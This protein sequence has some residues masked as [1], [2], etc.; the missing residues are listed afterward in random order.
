MR[1]FVTAAYNWSE[2]G[3]NEP[4]EG[5]RNQATGR[6]SKKRPPSGTS[7]RNVSRMP[8]IDNLKR[9]QVGPWKEAAYPEG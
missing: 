4:R 2:R 3:H 9:T 1:P 7:N 6:S 5:D 8:G